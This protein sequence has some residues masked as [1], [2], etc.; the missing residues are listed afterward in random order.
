MKNSTKLFLLSLFLLFSSCRTINLTTRKGKDKMLGATDFS[1]FNGVYANIPTHTV[2]LQKTLFCAFTKG[3]KDTVCRQ[4]KYEVKLVS[5]HPEK[6]TLHLQNEGVTLKSLTLKGKYKKGYFKI[7]RQLI[8]DGILGPLFWVF[9][10]NTSYI[11]LTRDN[12]L[13]VLNSG[14]TGV[15]FILVMPISV[16]GNDQE[17]MEYKRME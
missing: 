10:S 6:L 12:D 9:G 3:D 17:N 14:G 13:V 2:A 7:N 4:K 8:F 11:G 15:L 5:D 16:S 1:K